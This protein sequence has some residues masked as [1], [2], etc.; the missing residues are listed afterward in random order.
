MISTWTLFYLVSGYNKE[1][2][3]DPGHL[4]GCECT[5]TLIWKDKGIHSVLYLKITTFLWCNIK[6][7]VFD[8]QVSLFCVRVLIY[9]FVSL[10]SFFATMPHRSKQQEMEWSQFLYLLLLELHTSEEQKLLRHFT[11]LPSGSFCV[12]RLQAAASLLPVPV[13]HDGYGNSPISHLWLQT[14]LEWC[15]SRVPAGSCCS[16]SGGMPSL[17][18]LIFYNRIQVLHVETEQYL[19]FIK[20]VLIVS[21]C[22][23][24]FFSILLKECFVLLSMKNMLHLALPCEDSPSFSWAYFHCLPSGVY[25]TVCPVHKQSLFCLG[26]CCSLNMNRKEDLF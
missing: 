9:L 12:G 8:V 24:Y 19:L 6:Y 11:D 20:A 17:P 22:M 14:P 18:L 2:Y 23:T 15:A 7:F 13:L 25:I 3:W 5:C 10:L 4:K 21:Q 26:Y 1:T 16:C